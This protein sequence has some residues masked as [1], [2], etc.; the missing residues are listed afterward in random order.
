MS[1]THGRRNRD[2]A[3]IVIES[4]QMASLLSHPA[5][6]LALV[7]LAERRSISPG[8]FVAGVVGSMLPDADVIGYWL[9]VPYAHPLG[10]RGFSHSIAAAALFGLLMVALRRPLRAS[11]GAAFFFAFLAM[12]SHGLLDAMTT[13]GL[14][15]EFFWPVDTGRYFLPLRPI[16]V[17]PIRVASFLSS[18]GLR[19]LRSELLFIWLP[20]LSLFLFSL[21]VRR[22][23]GRR[24]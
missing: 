1:Q 6:C 4:L 3:G 20:C 10:H 19:V 13:G 17:S 14:G 2:R 21:I 8:L 24:E 5:V 23:E 7:A 18:R 22:M 16:E 9:G 11:A 12:L 15:V